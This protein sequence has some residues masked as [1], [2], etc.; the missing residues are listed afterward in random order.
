[1]WRIFDE[2]TPYVDC[3]DLWFE[4]LNKEEY[5]DIHSSIN[6]Q[7]NPPVVIERILKRWI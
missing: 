2:M 7:I 1:M 6:Y 3:S 4:H 5:N